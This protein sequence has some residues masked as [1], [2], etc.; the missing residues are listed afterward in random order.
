LSNHDVIRHATRY[1]LPTDDRGM[2]HQHGKAWLLSDGTTPELDRGLG[3]RRARAATLLMLALPG[4]AYLP[5]HLPQPGWFGSLSVEAQESDPQSTLLFYRRALSLRR[6]LRAAE[7]LEW[8][9]NDSRHVPHFRRPGGW[10]SVTNFGSE[11]VA[12]PDGTVIVASAPLDGDRL[13][14]DVTAWV[15]GPHSADIG[16]QA[17]PAQ[18]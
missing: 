1:G 11:P 8:I 12:L 18:A 2:M 6:K 15:L 9:Q 13:P 3:I 7:D 14:A 10:Q 17:P 5:A 4:S 16:G